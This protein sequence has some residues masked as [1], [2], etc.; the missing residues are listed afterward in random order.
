[1]KNILTTLSTYIQEAHNYP[2]WLFIFFLYA[3]I[4]TFGICGVLSWYPHAI[5]FLNTTP[6]TSKVLFESA[7]GLLLMGFITAPI[8]EI[9]LRID[10][11]EK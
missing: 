5:S 10:L 1:M 9:I 7:I 4:F 3:S 6:L 2:F 8:M 11:G